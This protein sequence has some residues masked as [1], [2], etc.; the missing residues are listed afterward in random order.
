VTSVLPAILAL[1]AG[2]SV[3][4]ASIT[5]AIY[6]AGSGQAAR[7]RI[8]ILGVYSTYLLFGLA[9]TLGPA[10]ALRSA[11]AGTS[12]IFE[13]MVEVAV[14]GLLVGIGIR[15]CRQRH[16]T[17]AQTA[18]VA[19]PHTRSGLALGV[20]ATLA[21]LP[22]A[23]PLLIAI[24]LLAGANVNVWAQAAALGLYN[25][26]YVSPLLAVAFAHALSARSAGATTGRRRGLLA[27]THAVAALCLAVGAV[28]GCEGITALV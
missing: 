7:L 21:D 5:G 15:A 28:I 19:P 24:T 23:G 25:V 4:P 18:Q 26:V 12:T 27:R 2:D 14:G 20:A 17:R 16:S 11:I 9:L 1:A 8:F 22:T 13:P 6:L 3:N 10:A